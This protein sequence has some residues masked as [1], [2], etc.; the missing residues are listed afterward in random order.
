VLGHSLS[1]VDRAYFLALVDGLTAGPTWTVAI[2]AADQAP[3]KTQCLTAFGVPPEQVK[4]N[5]WSER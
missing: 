4:C 5:L 2:R 1:D 3:A